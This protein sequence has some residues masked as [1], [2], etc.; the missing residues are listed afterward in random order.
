MNWNQEAGSRKQEARVENGPKGLT[1]RNKRGI[2]CKVWS[3]C[4]NHNARCLEQSL[5]I[6]FLFLLWPL[7]YFFF[8]LLSFLIDEI[9]FS[10][11]KV[12]RD[13]LLCLSSTALIYCT[14]GT[15]IPNP[16]LFYTCTTHHTQIQKFAIIPIRIK[17]FSYFQCC[18][19]SKF[20][21]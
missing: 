4:S 7:F 13:L 9:F 20:V 11:I 14:W 12:G 8:F 17:I 19:D 1:C 21:F 2:Y 10:R 16:R 3:V 15:F 6:S 5:T 18:R